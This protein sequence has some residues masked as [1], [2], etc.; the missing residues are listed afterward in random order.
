VAVAFTGAGS[1]NAASGA[2]P[3]AVTTTSA[4]AV[5]DYL[6]VLISYDNSG[7]SGADPMTGTITATPASGTLGASVSSQSGLND[8]GVA[9]AGLAVRCEAFPVTS[10]ISSGTSVNI[11]W[12]GTLVVRAVAFM[13]VTG[14]VYRTNSGATGGNTVGA[15]AS[16]ALVTPSVNNTEGVL[17]WAGH[18]NG[19]AITGD[20]DTTNGTWSA[21]SGTFNGTGATGMAA[22]FQSKVVTATATQSFSATGTSSDWITGCLIF[23]QPVDTT[24]TSSQSWGGWTADATGVVHAILVPAT[25]TTSW[26]T[27]TATAIAGTPLYF[28]TQ[29]ELPGIH[30][31]D[32]TANL[33]GTAVGWNLPILLATTRGT[34]VTNQNAT[35]VAGPTAGIEVTFTIT[36]DWVSLPLD[37]DVTISGTIACSLWASESLSTVNAAINVVIERLDSTGAIVS[38]IGRSANTTEVNLTT[39]TVNEFTIT[40]TSTNMLKGDRI[41]ARVF[42]DDAGT[43]AAGSMAFRFNAASGDGFSYISFAETF[44]VQTTEP[45]GTQLFLTTTTGPAVGANDEREMWTS[46]GGTFTTA[47]VNTASGWTAPIQWTTSA[48]GTAIEW[49]SRPLSAFTLDGLV[50]LNLRAFESSASANAGIRAEIAVCNNDGSGA[51]V[52][53][54]ADLVDQASIGGGGTGTGF[55]EI[56]ITAPAA[57]RSWLAGETTNVTDGQRLRLRVFVDDKADAPLVTGFTAS[58]AYNF[59]S[60]STGDSWIQLPQTVSEFV[61]GTVSDSWGGLTATAAGDV[62]S[63]GPIDWPGTV[64]SSWGATT[65]TATATVEHP[66]TVA[67]DWGTTSFTATGTRETAATVSSSWGATTFTATATPDHPATISSSWGSVTFVATAV[68]EEPAT[69]TSSWGGWTATAT[70]GLDHPASVSSSWGATSFTATAIRETAATSTT[71]WGT[72]AFS[73]TG[74]PDHV[75]TVSSSWG[76]TTF[77][78][79]GTVV[80]ETSGTIASSW[81]SLSASGTALVTHPATVSS[82]WGALTLSATAVRETAATI[83]TSWGGWTASATAIPTVEAT[84]PAAWG[85][86]T[87][88]ATASAIQRNGTV[89]SDWGALTATATASVTH[90]A[91]VATS[92]GAWTATALGTQEGQAVGFITSSWGATTFVATATVEHSASVSTS[93]G[94]T[95]IAATGTVERS[96]ISTTSWGTVAFSA[97]GTRTTAGSISTSWGSATFTATGTVAGQVAGSVSTTWGPASFTAIATPD[98]PATINSGWGAVSFTATGTTYTP[99]EV[100]A[101]VNT[102]W[103]PWVASAIGIKTA[104]GVIGQWNGQQFVEWQFGADPI[105]EWAMG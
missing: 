51:V 4:L 87:F 38:E 23:R 55:G 47:V 12:T 10:A 9:S 18:E 22:Y 82:S 90:P 99:I 78:A 75:A 54:A 58:L 53:A 5:G 11:A 35:T 63:G 93:W 2:S 31:G 50:R 61:S 28:R 105:E 34:A 74:A 92:W 15:T 8:P 95:T 16:T 103:S 77:S 101:S 67:S 71:S 7:T 65:F 36:S 89:T 102:Q 84:G 24:A 60:G 62:T 32:N 97:T 69:I 26:G 56:G 68:A 40:P 13:K 73:A 81:G 72:V 98:H 66:A 1:A 19:A 59:T 30:R 42:A 14:A 39:A 64:S 94:A 76:A 49:Y 44:G 37:R 57:V 52:W 3:Q 27:A 29:T 79:T 91:T 21:V 80:H 86:V 104:L 46:R 33:R 100:L 48:G 85:A 20:A 25:V 41:R 43:M 45:T 6:V 17:C 88:T 70:G 96:A 83:A